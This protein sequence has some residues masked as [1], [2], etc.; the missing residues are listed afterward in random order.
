VQCP[1]GTE[2]HDCAGSGSLHNHIE[3]VLDSF[4]NVK[5]MK[6]GEHESRQTRVEFPAVINSLSV[7]CW[8]IGMTSSSLL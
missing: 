1:S 2:E 8:K 6:L 7:F 3:L 4:R 5:P